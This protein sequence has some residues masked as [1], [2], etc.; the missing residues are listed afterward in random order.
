MYSGFNNFIIKNVSCRPPSPNNILSCS[1]PFSSQF[2]IPFSSSSH[3]PHPIFTNIFPAVLFPFSSSSHLFFSHF[4][5]SFFSVPIHFLLLLSLSLPVPTFSL[6][7]HTLLSQFPSLF[8]PVAT[9]SLPLTTI[10]F[11]AFN[12]SSPKVLPYLFHPLLSYS[13]CISSKF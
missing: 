10:F 5:S 8:L 1:N 3:F 6:P 9:D 12:P 11:S 2:L 7:S 13:H 4:L